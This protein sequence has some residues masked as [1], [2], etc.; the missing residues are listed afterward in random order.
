MAARAADGGDGASSTADGGARP[1]STARPTSP[2]PGD[3]DATARWCTRPGWRAGWRGSAA[4]ARR[5][6]ARAHA[7]APALD[8]TGGVVERA[9]RPAAPS[10]ADRV[11][12]ATNVFPSL[13]RRN[14]LLTVPVYDYVLMTEPLTADAA[15]VDRLGRTGRASATSANQ[16]HYYRLTA[17]NRILWGGYDAIYHYG[18]PVAR[19]LRGPAGDVP[20]GW[21]RTSSRPSRSSRASA[22]RHRWAG[23]IDTSTRFAAFYGTAPRRPGRLRRRLHRP[24]RRRHPLRRRGDAR[25][26]RRAADRA[27]PAARWCASGRCRSRRS[28]SP[29]LGINA[30]PLVARPRR[31]PRG[32]AQPLPARPRPGRAGVRLL[33]GSTAP[34]ARCT[35]E[36]RVAGMGVDGRSCW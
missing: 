13:L 15:G 11:A 34:A 35:A 14:R 9:H 2:A 20:S 1:R 17:D 23:A 19:A 24:R 32:P 7:G 29:R 18:R 6:D 26:A 33:R 22:S 16:F 21:P 36:T 5:R 3:R 25:P 27:H 30:H 8:A 28:R 10:R 12:L 4:D 31:P